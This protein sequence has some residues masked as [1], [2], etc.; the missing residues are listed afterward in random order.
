LVAIEAHQH[1]NQHR[2]EARG[3]CSRAKAVNDALDALLGA[4]TLI[5]I[6]VTSLERAGELELLAQ[7]QELHAAIPQQVARTT[8]W[9]GS[10]LGGD[11]A[12]AGTPAQAAA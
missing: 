4:E 5:A 10:S 3:I 8:S 9:R 1:K 6:A 2:A 7:A 12:G 11:E